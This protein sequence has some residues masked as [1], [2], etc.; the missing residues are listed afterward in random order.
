MTIFTF[1]HEYGPTST[2]T[3]I[4]PLHRSHRSKWLGHRDLALLQC[5]EDGTPAVLL[6]G[7]TR[8]A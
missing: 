6:L 5:F 8:D 3:Y 4:W 7:V 2:H 1:R